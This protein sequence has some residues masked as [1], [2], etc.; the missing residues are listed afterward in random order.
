M[1]L[2]ICLLLA[3]SLCL[4]ANTAFCE[5]NTLFSFEKDTEG[6]EVPNWCLEKTDYVA[7]SIAVSNKFAKDGKSA[8]EIMANFP[9]GKW[10]ATYV[11]VQQFFDWAPYK[12]V[13]VDVYLPKE[14]PMGLQAKI[15]LTVGDDWTWTEM[16]RMVKLMPGEW[17]TVSAGLVPGVTDWRRTTVT[18]QFRSDIRKFGVRIESNMRPTYSG[19]IYIDNIKLE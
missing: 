6:W 13:S 12:T 5:P 7:E 2:I 15:I 14:A 8:L 10:T 18:D 4:A 19:P 9:G 16:S 1:K 11:E 17:V 3:A